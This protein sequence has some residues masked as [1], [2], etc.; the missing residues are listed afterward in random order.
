M[1][2]EDKKREIFIL[3]RPKGVAFDLVLKDEYDKCED[4]FINVHAL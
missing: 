3:R 4:C 1:H 2:F